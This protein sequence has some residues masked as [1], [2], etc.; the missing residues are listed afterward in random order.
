MFKLFPICYFCEHG[1]FIWWFALDKLL[2]IEFPSWHVAPLQIP[3]QKNCTHCDSHHIG[4]SCQKV[5][6]SKMSQW[7]ISGSRLSSYFGND[8][9]K[10]LEGPSSTLLHSWAGYVVPVS[11]TCDIVL[12]VTPTRVCPGRA[13][14]WELGP[15]CCS[16]CTLGRLKQGRG[17]GQGS[18]WRGKALVSPLTTVVDYMT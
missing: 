18:K 3:L 10:S 15:R 13:L 5:K 12:L 16:I 6:Y 4:W 9:G 8:S 1:A 7:R 14:S 11:R 2:E 17:K